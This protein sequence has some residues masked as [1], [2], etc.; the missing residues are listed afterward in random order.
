M[1]APAYLDGHPVEQ[2]VLLLKFL[3]VVP[4]DELDYFFTNYAHSRDLHA[5]DTLYEQG[6][7]LEHISAAR[8]RRRG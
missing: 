5:R 2:M 4:P 8:S 6:A 3:K 7:A 1:S